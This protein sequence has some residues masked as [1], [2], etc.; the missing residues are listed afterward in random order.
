MALEKLFLRLYDFAL[1]WRF[2]PPEW[3]SYFKI[4]R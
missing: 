3:D 2:F 4:L 1:G